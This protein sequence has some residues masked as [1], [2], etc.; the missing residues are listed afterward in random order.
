MGC[1]KV[2]SETSRVSEYLQ[3]L[4]LEGNLNQFEASVVRIPID[5]QD[6]H[7]VMTTCRANR[8]HDG[9]I[10]V[11]NKALSD[12]LS[13]LEEMF[14]NL[15]GFVDGE[16]LSDCE[17]A[18]GNKLLLYLQCCLAGRAYPFGSLPDDLVDKIPLQT[19]RCLI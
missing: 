1:N 2:H 8:L 10:Y 11:Y 4:I 9:I 15:S 3:N 18:Q 16:V 5:R 7:Y 6:I 14:E 17:I 13:P 12:Y 19:Y